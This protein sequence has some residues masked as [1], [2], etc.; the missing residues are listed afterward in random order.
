MKRDGEGWKGK[1]EEKAG[2]REME[3][4]LSKGKEG[5]TLKGIWQ[6]RGMKERFER[7]LG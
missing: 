1:N 3:S 7:K 5:E 2:G 4:K 6:G